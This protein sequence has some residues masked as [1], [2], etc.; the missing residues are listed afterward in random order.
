MDNETRELAALVLLSLFH[1]DYSAIVNAFIEANK[2]RNDQDLLEKLAIISNPNTITSAK[3]REPTVL[4]KVIRY[5]NVA[6]AL[7]NPRETN[8][9]IDYRQTFVRRKGTWHYLE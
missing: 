4:G 1:R 6:E 3:G 8:V 5:K 2:G 7:S 9:S